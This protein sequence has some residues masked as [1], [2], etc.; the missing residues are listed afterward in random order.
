MIKR[1]YNFDN[2]K[3]A[4]LFDELYVKFKQH[5]K[6]TVEDAVFGIGRSATEKEILDFFNEE[7]EGD[8][9]PLDLVVEKIKSTIFK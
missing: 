8:D 1:V 2:E 6:L 4:F 5:K 9:L 7:D 3:Q